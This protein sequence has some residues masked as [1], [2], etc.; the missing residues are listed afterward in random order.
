MAVCDAI[1]HGG[2]GRGRTEEED[3][4]DAIDGGIRIRRAEGLFRTFRIVGE[5]IARLLA[6]LDMFRHALDEQ[7]GAQHEADENALHQVAED[8]DE[9]GCRDHDR[10]APGGAE[11]GGI[12]CF[13]IM[14]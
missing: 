1:E 9:E 10:I 13:S 4:G 14:L 8:D 2:D 3:A 6:H 5:E 11:E 12:A 7:E